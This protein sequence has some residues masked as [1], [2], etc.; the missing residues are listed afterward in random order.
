MFFSHRNTLF[1]NRFI[2]GYTV[3]ASESGTISSIKAG[4]HNHRFQLATYI[5]HRL[6]TKE[7]ST[8]PEPVP[9]ISLKIGADC[10]LHHCWFK[11]VVSQGPAS[12]LPSLLGTR[13]DHCV[14]R[15]Q[16]N[17]APALSFPITRLIRRQLLRAVGSGK[18]ALPPTCQNH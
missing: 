13:S 7:P 2:A 11:H 9:S 17:L 3:V 1:K 18:W 5:A 15:H 6:H 16:P 10:L 4:R 14:A 12:N 8:T